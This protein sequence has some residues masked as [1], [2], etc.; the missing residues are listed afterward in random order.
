[1]KGIVDFCPGVF[2]DHGCFSRIGAGTIGGKANG[3]VFI[4]E[5]L[6]TRL[7]TSP[8]SKISVEIPWMTVVAADCFKAFMEQNSL[9]ETANSDLPDDR[10]AHAFLKADLPAELVGDL[11]SIAEQVRIPLAIRSSSL[12]EDALYRPFAGVYSTKMIPNNQPSADER[13]RKLAEAI[14]LVYA[15]TYFKKA[16]NYIQSINEDSSSEKMA[17]IIQRM[18]GRRFNDRY[19]PNLSGVARSFN[20]YP[21]GHARFEDGVV[22]LALGLGKMIVDGGRVWSYC[23]AYPKSPPPFNNTQDLLK[24]TQSDFWAVN[25]GEPPTYDPIRETEYMVKAAL[26]DADYDNTLKFTASTYDPGSD[27]IIPG[28]GRKGPRIINFAPILMLN[29][30]PLNDIVLDLLSACS[31]ALKS[32]VE[33]EF[34]LTFD[35]AAG[36]PVQLGFLQVRPMVGDAESADLPIERLDGGDVVVATERALGN[37]LRSD[38]EDIVYIRPDGFEPKHSGL[39]PKELESINAALAKER[40]PYLLI[41]FGRWGTSD[42]WRGIPVTWDQIS[43]ARLIVEASF[44]GMEADFSQGSHFFHNL[45]SFKVS[46]FSIPGSGKHKLDM[47][48]IEN[49]TEIAKTRFVRHVRTAK[50]LTVRVDGKKG[51][52]I[53]LSHEG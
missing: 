22:D 50:P 53:I 20:Y 37:S 26:E 25:M 28:V 27:R 10:V 29:D 35:P 52:G 51:R 33:I 19:Y 17:V 18:V 34:A 49:Q 48:W 47:E 14:K 3:L 5:I 11:R 42:P 12:L 40:R 39:I 30:I 38:I 1:M 31:D 13:Y 24:N 7:D 41:G 43:W 2:S 45:T 15:S 44:A 23:P 6:K 9:F 46:Y 36:S 8:A 4:K 32:E 21:F 16:K